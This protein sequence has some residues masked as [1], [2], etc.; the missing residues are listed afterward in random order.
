MSGGAAGASLR[1]GGAG[2]PLPAAARS[3]LGAALVRARGGDGRG[4]HKGRLARAGAVPGGA[5]RGLRARRRARRVQLDV[6]G[7]FAH[8]PRERRGGGRGGRRRGD[9][10]DDA[11]GRGEELHPR[12]S[13]QERGPERGGR[14]D[15]AVPRHRSPPRRLRG[16]RH[17]DHRQRRVGRR[18]PHAGRSR[19]V[20]RAHHRRGR[21]QRHVARIRQRHGDVLARAPTRGETRINR[22]GDLESARR[23]E[24]RGRSAPA[25]VV[26]AARSGRLGHRGGG[27]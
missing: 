22:R 20:R 24:T 7:R 10:R 16:R 6:G 5:G 27:R 26:G 8:G 9:H 13:R 3:D 12:A 4:L 25:R 11:R 15:D 23:F 17:H 19:D 21:V 2:P 1:G 14:D 18:D